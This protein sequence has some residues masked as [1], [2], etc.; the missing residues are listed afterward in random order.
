[1]VLIAGTGTAAGLQDLFNSLKKP[2]ATSPHPVP[3]TSTPTPTPTPVPK[4]PTG[5]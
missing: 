1:M 4:T 2:P 5:K 3:P